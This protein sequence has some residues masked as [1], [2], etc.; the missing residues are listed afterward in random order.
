MPS[1]PPPSSPLPP[2]G[3]PVHTRSTTTDRFLP[4]YETREHTFR[5]L[6]AEMSP[7]FVGPVPPQDFLDSFLPVTTPCHTV[8]PFKQGMFSTLSEATS[9]ASMY[10]TF[11]GSESLTPAHT[12]DFFFLRSKLLHHSS[13]M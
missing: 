3:T 8:L 7:Y 12:I 13:K 9:E 1:T 5:R 2:Q 10:K 6:S 11:V 4:K